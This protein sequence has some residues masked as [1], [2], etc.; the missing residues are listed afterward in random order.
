MMGYE[1][2]GLPTW[3]G[4]RLMLD[5]A[6][7]VPFVPAPPPAPAPADWQRY[8]AAITRHKWLVAI[9]TL[10]GT[11]TGLV[12]TRFLD[13]RY[14]AKAILW[15]E[16]ATDR[17]RDVISSEELLEAPGWVDLVTSNAVLD[18]VVRQLRLYLLPP[19]PADSAILA[20][21]RLT[22][23]VRPG[24][25]RLTVDRDGRTFRLVLADGGAEVQ[26]GRVGDPVGASL[27]FQWSPPV[28]ALSPGRVLEFEVSAPYDAAQQ[29]A[30]S[31]KVRLDPGGNFLRL[32]LKGTNPALTAATLNAIAGRI[33]TVAAELKRQKFQELGTILGGQYEHAQAT[34]RVA[35]AALKDFRV[36]TAGSGTSLDT[37]EP[38]VTGS[39]DLRQQL[40]DLRRDRRAI[41][42]ALSGT[43]SDGSLAEALAAIPA[44]V[45]SPDVSLALQELTKK[46]ADLRGLR[47]RYTPE[48]APVRQ[49]MGELDVLEHQVIP[50][51][52][53]QLVAELSTREAQLTARSET[54]VRTLRRI[55][56][57]AL[58]EARLTRDV[59]SAEE[60]FTNV[61]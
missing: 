33:V 23:R 2:A 59:T 37:R 36:R 6:S 1:R 55:P 39:F 12:A 9:V 4:G 25:Y 53:R 18:S 54:A 50:A 52:A 61:R 31:L 60:M 10:L 14:T 32:Q 3:P 40:D 5:A 11:A 21:F 34:L 13:P 49:L 30:R 56:S 22:D 44:V 35:E 24:R 7:A 38:V 57:L 41:E 26:E 29:L 8:I 27:G 15:I 42:E 47:Y 19:S 48:S 45:H 17:D 58:E 20:S 43:R 16:T 51:L 46:Q 28:A